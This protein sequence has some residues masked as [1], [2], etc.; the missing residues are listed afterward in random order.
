MQKKKH[1]TFLTL[2]GEL[3]ITERVLDLHQCSIPS[4][5]KHDKYKGKYVKIYPIN[6]C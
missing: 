4:G 1:L 5:A 6:Y 3:V 2:T